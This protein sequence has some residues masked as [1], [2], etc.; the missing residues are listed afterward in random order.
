MLAGAARNSAISVTPRRA[1]AITTS[2]NCCASCCCL[3]SDQCEAVLR[4]SNS[5]LTMSAVGS[6]WRTSAS[7]TSYDAD[8]QS[9][10][11]VVPEDT[12]SRP[13]TVN[14]LPS[15][16]SSSGRHMRRV[17][18][19]SIM[20]VWD[21]SSTITPSRKSSGT[22]AS[23]PRTK[24]M[25]ARSRP[26]Q[27]RE[28]SSGMLERRRIAT[29]G[30]TICPSTKPCRTSTMTCSRRPLTKA[31]TAFS[32]ASPCQS[33]SPRASMTMTFWRPSLWTSRM[34]RAAPSRTMN[35]TTMNT[36]QL[37]RADP[38]PAESQLKTKGPS[39]VGIVTPT[40]SPTRTRPISGRP[41]L[42]RVNPTDRRLKAQSM[43][44]RTKWLNKLRPPGFRQVKGLRSGGTACRS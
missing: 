28:M 21:S 1:S 43:S 33:R 20:S 40:V 15:S 12:T 35:V 16:S 14:R 11:R 44:A 42:I 37:S 26:A 2:R 38:P 29:S 36:L 10:T 18:S 6:T 13:T 41:I 9:A 4:P 7:R 8:T 3:C 19:Q 39:A 23:P 32:N 22:G 17:R 34:M 25:S 30:L 24:D 5:I 31:G 27:R